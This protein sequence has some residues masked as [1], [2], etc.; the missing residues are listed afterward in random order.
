MT[1]T[2]VCRRQRSRRRSLL[3]LGLLQG[4]AGGLARASGL[5]PRLPKGYVDLSPNGGASGHPKPA[6]PSSIRSPPRPSR[7]S[8]TALQLVVYVA[9]SARAFTSSIASAKRLLISV[10]ASLLACCI[11]SE[12]SFMLASECS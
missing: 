2:G 11:R 5:A 12:T 9:F 10:S 6:T 7:P 4:P 1:P 8:W 3:G